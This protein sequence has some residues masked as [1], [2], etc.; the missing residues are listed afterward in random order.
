LYR[1]LKHVENGFY[2]RKAGL[3]MY[4][5]IEDGEFMNV[6]YKPVQT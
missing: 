6:I 3:L 4:D 5:F 2:A 1:A